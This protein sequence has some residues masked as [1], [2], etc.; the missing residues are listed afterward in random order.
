MRYILGLLSSLVGPRQDAN[1]SYEGDEYRAAA[2]T[3]S[4]LRLA[5]SAS[6]SICISIASIVLATIT[7][8]IVLFQINY[9]EKQAR[10]AASLTHTNLF[11]QEDMIA[12]TL[13]IGDAIRSIESER[14]PSVALRMKMLS[15][16][17]HLQDLYIIFGHF[18][19]LE[20]CV[21]ANV[22]DRWTAIQF[23]SD[24]KT[25][26]HLLCPVI[27]DI[28]SREKSPKYMG[29]VLQLLSVDCS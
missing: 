16:Q 9:S 1:D 23:L 11:L 10:I 19:A 20:R 18:S 26:L 21:A 8:I 17:K 27:R 3:I 24:E 29:D 12:R 7:A 15:S 14:D 5:N 22:C 6:I 4:Q 2:T 25:F 13:R 28:R